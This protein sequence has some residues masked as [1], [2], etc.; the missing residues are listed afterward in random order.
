MWLLL[1]LACTGSKEGCDTCAADT[2]DTA[3]TSSAD[4]DIDVDSDTDADTDS[5]SDVDIDTDTDADIDTDTDADADTGTDTDVDTGTCPDDLEPPGTGKCPDACTGGCEL[6]V[7]TIECDSW[8]AC[9]DET[10]ACPDGW[11]CEEIGR[12][13]V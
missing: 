7:C 3:Q 13:H 1:A 4:T 5:D 9:A 10:L 8:K 2:G 11:A 6:D 12:A